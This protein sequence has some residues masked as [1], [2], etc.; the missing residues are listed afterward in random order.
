MYW[1]ELYFV[2]CFFPVCN[3]SSQ[4]IRRFREHRHSML[5]LFSLFQLGF[6]PI[7]CFHST[8]KLIQIS[9][10]SANRFFF[11]KY[12]SSVVCA[13]KF[14]LVNYEVVCQLSSTPSIHQWHFRGRSP[15]N[16]ISTV[17]FE[18]AHLQT[19]QKREVMAGDAGKFE[20]KNHDFIALFH[21]YEHMSTCSN[22][23]IGTNSSNIIF[24]TCIHQWN[25]R[26]PLSQTKRISYNWN[27]VTQR[28]A[29]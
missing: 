21:P 25:G 3:F 5:E 18:L 26:I 13:W 14:V 6:D 4:P 27:S 2:L 19:N 24:I 22:M 8:S 1:Y 9:A 15:S 16:C 7:K 10:E 20:N 29:E 17:A 23:S 12:F 28:N 11:M